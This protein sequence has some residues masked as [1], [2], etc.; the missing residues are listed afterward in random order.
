MC[1][2]CVWR[3]I[4]IISSCSLSPFH[5]WFIFRCMDI[6]RFDHPFTVWCVFRV[7]FSFPWLWLM[8]SYLFPCSMIYVHF[9]GYISRSGMNE[10]VAVWHLTFWGNARVF[11]MVTIPFCF[12]SLWGEGRSLWLQGLCSFA[13]ARPCPKSTPKAPATPC[14]ASPS[15]KKKIM[16]HVCLTL[17]G[18]VL[19]NRTLG[20]GKEQVLEM[21]QYW[22]S[23]SSPVMGSERKFKNYILYDSNSNSINIHC[24]EI[25]T[26]PIPVTLRWGHEEEWV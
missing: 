10:Y 14:Q 4:P 17:Q 19:G 9:L 12:P 1:D 5:S 15:A 26:P 21:C 16:S 24:S 3:L 8:L 13:Q 2:C 6:I 20:L 23:S 11:P 25:S 18:E 7:A 22:T